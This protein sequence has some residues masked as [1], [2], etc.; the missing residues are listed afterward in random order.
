MSAWAKL[1]DGL[2]EAAPTLVGAA[3]MAA[4]GPVVGG[5]LAALARKLVG[6]D[7]GADLESVATT[8]MADPNK[9]MEFRAEAQ[10]LDADLEKAYL[11]DRQDARKRDI[12]L[13]QAGVHNTRANAMVAMDAAGLLFGLGGMLA[14]G[15][16]KAS[17]PEAITEG[18]FGALLA[19]LSTITSYFGLCLRDAHQFEFGSS[20]GSRDK[21]ILTRQ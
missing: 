17:H 6:A 12:A 14:L 20:R 10:R 1:V 9:M 13:S 2:K 18:V 4:G 11:G 3:G 8:L 15:W 7:E 5:A 19:Q 16:F 21:D